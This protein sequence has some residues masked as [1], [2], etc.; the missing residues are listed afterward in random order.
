MVNKFFH[1]NEKKIKLLKLI[2]TIPTD[3]PTFANYLQT[4]LYK[5]CLKI[6]FVTLSS[7]AFFGQH[8]NTAESSKL[9]S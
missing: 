5:T 2:Q 9:L 7:E 4:P 3:V 6:D 8:C 1:S